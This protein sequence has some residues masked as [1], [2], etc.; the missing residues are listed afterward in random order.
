[1][2]IALTTI[3]MYIFCVCVFPRFKFVKI[4]FNHFVVTTKK[5]SRIF[6]KEYFGVLKGD[7][8]NNFMS[9]SYNEGLV[10]HVSNL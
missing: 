5:I 9:G 4:E 8:N 2:H 10:Y 7:N 1:M 6:L 3:P